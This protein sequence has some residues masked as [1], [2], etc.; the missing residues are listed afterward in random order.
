MVARAS[1]VLECGVA[2]LLDL[3]GVVWRGSVAVPGATDAVVRLREAG[4][5]VGFVTNNS[6]ATRAEVEAKLASQ[7]IEADGAVVTSATAAGALLSPGER[8]LVCGGPGAD[9]AVR[10]RGAVVV[11]ADGGS[12]PVGAVDAVLMG[13]NPAF[14]Y[15]LMTAATVAVLRGARL[16]AT[17]DD[18]T[19]PTADGL[20]PGGGAILASVER[21]TGVSALV[22]GKPHPTMCDYVV[23]RFGSDGVM[24]GDRPDTDG[25]FGVALGYR[26]GLVLSGV[27]TAADLPVDPTPDLIGA[28]LGDLIAQELDS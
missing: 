19:Y 10:D 23:D 21:A 13:F 20:V 9:E 11:R 4:Q 25:R 26:F 3:D 2:W 27:T 24:V 22:A 28:D 12:A 15:A 5:A 7:G 18:A 14:D 8:V 6:Y 17:N 16:L 1:A